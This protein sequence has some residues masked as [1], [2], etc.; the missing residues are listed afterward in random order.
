MSEYVP[1]TKGVRDSYVYAGIG[2][3][4]EPITAERIARK[5][6]DTWLNSVKAD[7]FSEGAAKQREIV[8][9]KLGRGQT[10]VIPNNPYRAGG[11][12]V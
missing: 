9:H 8:E 4:G 5:E 12:N 2:Y 3:N 7:A 6:F 1:T 11:K 10:I